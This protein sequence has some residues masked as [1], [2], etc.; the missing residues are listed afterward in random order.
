LE[1]P[2]ICLTGFTDPDGYETTL[3][4]DPVGWLNSVSYPNGVQELRELMP[5]GAR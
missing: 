3:D 2:G 5:S 1:E 4:Y